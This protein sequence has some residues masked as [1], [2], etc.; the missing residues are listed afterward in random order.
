MINLFLT[1]ALLLTAPAALSQEAAPP[2]AQHRLETPLP[3]VVSGLPAGE[4]KARLLGERLVELERNS[5]LKALKKSARPPLYRHL[6]TA[7]GWVAVDALKLPLRYNPTLLQLEMELPP[8]DRAG[9]RLE[10]YEGPDEELKGQALPA[11]GFG[12][13]INY[14]VEKAWGSDTL[15]GEGLNAYTDSFLNLGGVVL[16]SQANYQETQ[17][18]GTGWFRGDTRLVKDF[19]KKQVRTEVGDVYPASFGFMPA[20]PVGGVMVARNFTLNPY[21]VPFPQGR[22]NFVLRTRSRVRTFV[23][24]VPVKDEML[25]PGNYDLRDVPLTNGLNTVLVE[26]TDELGD[27]RVYEF[28]LPTSVGLLKD[29]DWNFSLSHGKPFT[30]NLFRRSYDGDEVTSGYVQHGFTDHFSLGGYGQGQQGHTLGG[31]EAGLAT[32]A[33]NFFLGAA[34]VQADGESAG[35]GSGTWQL[36]K[37]GT[38]LF[39]TYTLTVRNERYGAGFS[40]LPGATQALKAQWQ[41]NITLPV[42]ELLTLSL[43]S[44]LGEVRDTELANRRGWDAAINLRAWR[45]L[46]LSFF[47][48]RTRDEYKQ[49]NDVAYAF[50]TWT[51]DGANHLISGFHD[52]ENKLNRVNLIHDNGNRLYEPRVSAT[53][54]ESVTRD[55]GELDAF[56]PTPMADLGGRYTAARFS[57]THST[58][59]RGVARLG[60]A[61]VFAHQNGRFGI[62]LSRPVPNS[63]V[64][65]KPS[66]DLK[67]QKLGLRSTSPY[68]EG[69]SGLFG[70]IT[71]TNLLPYQF[72]EV[73]I[74]PT[75]L[76][77]GTSLVQEK[78]VVYPTYR[79]AHLIPL[80]DKG[81]VVLGGQLVD[82]DGR[83]LGLRVGEVGGRPFFTTREGR[84]FIEGLEEGT[85]MLKLSDDHQGLRIRVPPRARGIKDLGVVPYREEE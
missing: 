47:M 48:S 42:R 83:P 70:E 49:W 69:A 85:H 29:G 82:K 35:A 63:F 46:N 67:R 84:F 4:V 59:G 50:F 36:Q 43:G 68:T 19:Q 80:E 16:E 40:A 79:S 25:P 55:S 2:F 20:R 38:R 34:A 65:F 14:R 66:P 73:Q 21:R 26:T 22:G 54:E 1:A 74:D 44:T 17:A 18:D 41:A 11:A 51:F 72:R 5:L 37:V 52:A 77:P 6:L 27:K 78:F 60:Q 58:H 10:L 31:V 9:R 61:I 23:N 75:N 53:A 13:A 45:N 33:G 8:K 15:G 81:T 57:D 3:L 24:G 39:D 76:D 62:G 71:Y 56:L 30:D 7:P 32:E 28:R 12:G 64:L